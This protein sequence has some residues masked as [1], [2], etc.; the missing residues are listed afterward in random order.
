MSDWTFVSD[1]SEIKV[2]LSLIITFYDR[3]LCAVT[4]LKINNVKRDIKVH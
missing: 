1:E 2:N 3:F 4:R